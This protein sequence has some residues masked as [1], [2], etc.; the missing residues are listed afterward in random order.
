MEHNY[1]EL[2]AKVFNILSDLTPLKADC[3]T[4]CGKNCCK[5]DSGTGML[6]FPGERTALTVKESDGRK[7][8][9]CG[10]V[11]DRETRPLSCRI[12]PFFPAVDPD[13]TVVPVTDTRGAAVC[14]LIPNADRVVFCG[15]F[16]DAVKKAGELLMTDPDCAAFLREVTEEIAFLNE[17]AE[18]F[19]L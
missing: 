7:I 6:L 19:R 5:G 17:A 16:I 1:D 15:E 13:G 8:A 18:K 11:C 14:P 3:G 10:G 4:V 9:I 12:F 2:Y